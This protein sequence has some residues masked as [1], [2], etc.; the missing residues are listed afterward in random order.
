MGLLHAAVSRRRKG[1]M[2]VAALSK[3]YEIADAVPIYLLSNFVLCK[4]V[5]YVF[6]VAGVGREVGVGGRSRPGL[7]EGLYARKERLVRR[8]TLVNANAASQGVC[9]SE[10]RD[11]YDCELDDVLVKR[12]RR[13]SVAVCGG[14]VAVIR[15]AAKSEPLLMPISDVPNLRPGCGGN[16]RKR[17]SMRNGAS[18]RSQRRLERV[19]TKEESSGLGLRDGWS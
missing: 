13:R 17:A 11:T 4:Y 14:A 15:S 16:K 2:Q 19:E 3:D 12:G 10:L 5:M 1:A 6:Q 7:P 18:K 9:Q 8:A